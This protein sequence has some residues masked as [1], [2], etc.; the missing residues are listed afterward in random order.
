MTKYSN[1]TLIYIE[2][3]GAYLMLHRNRKEK[4][5]NKDKW[6]GVGGHFE[7]RESPDECI[8][9]EVFEETGLTLTDYRLRSVIT[10]VSDKYETEYMF[11]YTATGFTGELKDC[12]EGTLEW[13]NK[14]DLGTLNLWE[15]DYIFLDLIE[16]RRDFFTLKLEYEGD[17]L[18]YHE[19]GPY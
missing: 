7:D 13:V 4:D 10:F 12:N 9:R 15:G 17:K 18:V 6:I 3:E 11:L 14:S 5:A 8:K 2:K 16:K 19:L 1:S